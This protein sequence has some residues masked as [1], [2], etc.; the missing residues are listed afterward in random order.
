[1]A[2]TFTASSQSATPRR[3]HVGAFPVRATYTANGTTIS[4]SDIVLCM[5]IPTG[6]WVLDGYISGTA[7]SG[8]S[9]LKVG[10]GSTD[11][12][13]LSLGTLSA[14]AGIKRFD[15]GT[16]PI[17]VSVSDD[18]TTRYQ[19]VFITHNGGSLTATHSIQVVV[20]CA[21]DP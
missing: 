14:T 10:L 16:L 1:M 7:G 17:K 4:T 8:A 2:T 20:W 3:V 13:L 11:N 15:G 12:N 21:V 19:Y 18:A 5:K 6:T 9:N